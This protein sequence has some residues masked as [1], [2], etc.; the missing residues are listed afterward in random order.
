[1]IRTVAAGPGDTVQSL[2]ARMVSDHPLEHFL[3][4]NGRTADQPLRSGE[5]V[6]IVSLAGL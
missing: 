2:A 1:M 3:T 5:L 6:K 4:L